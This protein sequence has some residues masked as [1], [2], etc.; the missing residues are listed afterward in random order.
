MSDFFRRQIQSE[1]LAALYDYWAGES[2]NGRLMALRDIDPAKICKSL[3]NTVLLDVVANPRR[4]HCRF[5]GTAI[6]GKNGKFLTDTYIGDVETGGLGS[7][8]VAVMENVVDEQSPAH[9]NGEFMRPDD[10]IDR[11]ERIALPLSSDG[12]TVDAILVGI[13]Y[14]QVEFP[15][16]EDLDFACYG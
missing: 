7:E 2:A 13:A 11:Y 3:P 10:T 5:A 15:E 12:T 8:A 16:L 14:A 4:F 6:D 9:L 1:K